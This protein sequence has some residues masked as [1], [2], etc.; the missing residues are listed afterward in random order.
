MKMGALKMM[1]VIWMLVNLAFAGNAPAVTSVAVDYPDNQLTINGSNFSPNGGMPS[2]T[3]A[4]NSALVL[5]YTNTD[6]V[7]S[8][9]S[10]SP[11]SG[12]PAVLEWI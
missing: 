8:I 1:L 6:V 3:F 12:C 4:G 11:Y 7:V 9:P 2:V 5:S 10:N